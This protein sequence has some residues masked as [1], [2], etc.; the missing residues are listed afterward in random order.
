MLSVQV[1]GRLN[2][3]LNK[4]EL[5]PG[6]SGLF[7]CLLYQPPARNPK[8]TSSV[9]RFPHNRVKG[10]RRQNRVVAAYGRNPNTNIAPD[11]VREPNATAEAGEVLPRGGRREV[12]VSRQQVDLVRTCAC[13]SRARVCALAVRTC[14][15]ACVRERAC[16]SARA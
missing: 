14:A 9:V 11:L 4:K 7:V 8:V 10:D 6:V 2:V 12:R 15:R 3:Q 1:R 13:A 5:S 16:V